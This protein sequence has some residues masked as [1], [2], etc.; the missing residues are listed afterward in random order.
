MALMIQKRNGRK[1]VLDITKI[2][3][4]TIEATDGLDGVSQS[5]LELDAHIKF[6]DGMSTSDIQDA[7]IKT[8]I[9][10]IDIDVPNWT[11]TAARLFIF[12]LY[13]RVGKVTHGIKG[14]PYCHGYRTSLALRYGVEILQLFQDTTRHRRMRR[15]ATA[16]VY[17]RAPR[18]RPANWY[19]ERLSGTGV[20]AP[21]MC[22]D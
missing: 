13:H 16:T 10:K 7:L 1:E 5:E 20:T 18:S 14:E 6:I 21:R 17:R 4:M 9:E 22:S 15:H 3:K 19:S 2:Q 12:D 8:A 11:F